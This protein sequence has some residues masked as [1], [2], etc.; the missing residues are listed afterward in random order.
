M[1]YL[2]RFNWVLKIDP[3]KQ[4]AIGETYS[5]SK[6]GSR[7]FPI[8]VPIDL[9]TLKRKAIAKIKVVNFAQDGQQT[10]GQFIVI[11][12]Y[13]SEEQEFLTTYWQENA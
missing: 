6:S 9:I 7:I 1:S 3:P 8:G 5:F 13:E 2:V 12:L 4:L 10:T 11:K